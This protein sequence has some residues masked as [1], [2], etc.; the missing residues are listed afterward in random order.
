M[1]MVLLRRR[2]H[3]VVEWH[4]FQWMS[5]VAAHAAHLRDVVVRGVHVLKEQ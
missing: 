5:A 1:G 4:E 3:P 2:K